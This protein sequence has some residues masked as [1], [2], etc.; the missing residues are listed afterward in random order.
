MEPEF[1]IPQLIDPARYEEGYRAGMRGERFHVLDSLDASWRA[2]WNDAKKEQ[3]ENP[4]AAHEQ[5]PQSP[6]N[7]KGF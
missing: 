2:G 4:D 3:T 5:S 7:L 1:G 6:L